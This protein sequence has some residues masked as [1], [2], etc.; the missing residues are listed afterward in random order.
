MGD[1]GLGMLACDYYAYTI[2]NAANQEFIAAYEK[3]YPGEKPTPQGYGAWQ[4]VMMYIEALKATGGDTTPAKVIEA[5]STMSL[6][7]PAG[8]VTIVPYKTAFIA[9][10]DFFML[11]VQKVGEVLTW[12]PVKTYE[13]VELGELQP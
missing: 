9:K 3:L 1:I 7:T 10:R 6:D 4:G 13:Q 12:V 11:E 5:M 8:K 2:D